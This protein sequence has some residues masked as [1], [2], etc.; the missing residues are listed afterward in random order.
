M[1]LITE[2]IFNTS[3]LTEENEKGEKEYFLEGVFMQSEV[4]NRN[5]R[6]YPKKV[7]ENAVQRYIEQQVKTNR[8]VGE[9]NHPN[10]PTVNYKEVSHKIESLVWNGNDIIGRAKILDTPNGNLV[11][12]LLDGGVQIGVS[13][14]GMGSVSTKENVDYI[15]DDFILNTID[16][17]QDPSAP[18]AYVNGIMEGVEW[19]KRGEEFI[20]INSE[21]VVDAISHGFKPK[22]TIRPNGEIWLT[23][24]K[25][26]K[27][28]HRANSMQEAIKWAETNGYKWDASDKNESSESRK[29]LALRAFINKTV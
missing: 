4:K 6:I 16:I 21:G 3:F 23:K 19:E 14:R 20:K 1:K 9:L 18:A 13:S 22:V 28:I 25:N 17:V 12:A 27:V 2:Q 10:G 5:G 29:L 15:S 7:L 26:G 8:A 11:K 24:D